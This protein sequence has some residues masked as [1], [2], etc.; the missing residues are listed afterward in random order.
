VGPVCQLPD[1]WDA[2]PTRLGMEV[3]YG[4]ISGPNS[5]FFF[6]MFPSFSVF[7]FKFQFSN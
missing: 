1:Q 7:C 5:V 3:G 4:D 6:S 2:G